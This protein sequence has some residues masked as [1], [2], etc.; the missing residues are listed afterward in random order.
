MAERY[1]VR[2]DHFEL[3]V[4]SAVIV[5]AMTVAY[6]D[7]IASDGKEDVLALIDRALAVAE[8][9]GSLQLKP[10]PRR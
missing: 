9:G 10:K 8:A 2:A 4:A 3:R 7:W 5:N 1:G 6:E